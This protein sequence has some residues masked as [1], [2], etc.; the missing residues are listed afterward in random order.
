MLNVAG[1]GEEWSGYKVVA[2]YS[3]DGSNDI[4]IRFLSV[5]TGCK[6]VVTI[7]FNDTEILVGTWKYG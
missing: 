6:S 3:A 4:E 5:E 7:T 1:T 2:A